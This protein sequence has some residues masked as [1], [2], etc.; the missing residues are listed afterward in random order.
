MSQIIY[1]NGCW[2]CKRAIEDLTEKYVCPQVKQHGADYEKEQQR[3]T[4]APFK[5]NGAVRQ[6]AQK[7]KK[8]W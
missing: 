8:L 2:G 3:D 1:K 7:F 6:K 4:K 5:T